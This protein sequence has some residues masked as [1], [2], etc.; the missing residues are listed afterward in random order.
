ME[1]HMAMKNVPLGRPVWLVL[2]ICGLFTLPG[3]GSRFNPVPVS[4]MVTVDGQPL[5][6][7]RLSFV[8]DAAKG[9]TTPVSVMA[10]IDAQGRYDLR[11]TAARR[12]DGG[13]GAPLGWYKVVVVIGAPGDPEC[14]VDPIF[15]NVDKTPLSIEVVENPEPGY[16]DLKLTRT[17]GRPIPAP[18]FGRPTPHRPPQNEDAK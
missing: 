15:L 2:C 6:H 9:N 16:Y 12:A 8:P 5:T 18:T 17:K 10:P 3:C 13:R 7:F 14:V 11:T 1:Y 4:G